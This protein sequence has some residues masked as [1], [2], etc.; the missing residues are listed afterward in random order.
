MRPGVSTYSPPPGS[1]LQSNLPWGSWWAQEFRK[2]QVGGWGLPQNLRLGLGWQEG[3]SCANTVLL[4]HWHHF[5]TALTINTA[6]CHTA[7]C[8]ALTCEEL[9]GLDQA[10]GEG[11]SDTP[12]LDSVSSLSVQT[13]TLILVTSV[14]QKNTLGFLLQHFP[15]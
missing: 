8:L 4:A 1:G 15:I 11:E 6:T 14:L 7:V 12:E 5:P 13:A 3:N 9:H 2:G 10:G